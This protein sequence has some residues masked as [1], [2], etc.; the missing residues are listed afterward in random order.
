MFKNLIIVE[1]QM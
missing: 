1:D